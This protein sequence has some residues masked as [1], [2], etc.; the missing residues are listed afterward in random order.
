[1]PRAAGEELERGVAG[2]QEALRGR[3]AREEV[4][5]VVEVFMRN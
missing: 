4:I 2:G 1:M 5:R 3:G